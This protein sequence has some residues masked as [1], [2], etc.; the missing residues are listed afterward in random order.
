MK[1][2]WPV[3]KLGEVTNIIYRYPSFYGYTWGKLGVP[4]IRGENIQPQGELDNNLSNY[5]FVSKEISDKFPR[6]ILEVGDIRL[7]PK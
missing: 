5:N 6:T 4:V 1:T 2:S 7:V 3:K